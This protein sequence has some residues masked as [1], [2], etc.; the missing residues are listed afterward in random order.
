MDSRELD[1]NIERLLELPL[2]EQAICVWLAAEP[3]VKHWKEHCRRNELIDCTDTYIECFGQWCSGTASD[4]EL[5]EIA[6]RLGAD[7]PED[8]R[9]DKDPTG[10]M[11]G[12]SLRDVAAIALDQSEEVH[13]DVLAT[14]VAYS[15]AAAT[16]NR[17]VPIEIHWDRLSDA[18]M[19]YVESWW[20]RCLDELPQLQVEP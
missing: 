1:R 3:V 11:A 5:N 4:D 18:E 13:E 10:G 20:R 8:L 2:R 7:L 14:A 19:Q 12:W 17:K 15:A 6:L 16:N 9:R